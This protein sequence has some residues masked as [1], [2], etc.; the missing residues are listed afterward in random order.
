MKQFFELSQAISALVLHHN[1]LVAGNRG[2]V[3]VELIV[4]RSLYGMEYYSLIILQLQ[5]WNVTSRLHLTNT[6]R[7]SGQV[8]SLDSWN[9]YIAVGST[10]VQLIQLNSTSE[11]KRILYTKNKYPVQV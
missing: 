7:M 4:D 6:L 9:E 3:C 2:M 1:S 5:V 8:V 10:S 11:P